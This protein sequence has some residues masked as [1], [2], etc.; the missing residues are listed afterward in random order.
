MCDGVAGHR[1]HNRQR[2]P[3]KSRQIPQGLPAVRCQP[4]VPRRGPAGRI[5]RSKRRSWSGGMRHSR[6]GAEGLPA[7]TRGRFFSLAQT[8]L[9]TALLAGRPHCGM[10]CLQTTKDVPAESRLRGRLEIEDAIFHGAAHATGG[11]QA[12]RGRNGPS[13]STA[14]NGGETSPES[15]IY[16]HFNGVGPFV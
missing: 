15:L 7:D 10:G 5:M 9:E 3:R 8:A 1:W 14:E 13:R 12:A 4:A 6:G 16:G 2:R 11:G